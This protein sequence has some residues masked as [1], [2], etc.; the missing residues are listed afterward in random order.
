MFPDAGSSHRTLAFQALNVLQNVYNNT[1][2]CSDISRLIAVLLFVSQAVDE[3]EEN[4]S[5]VSLTTEEVNAIQELWQRV[6]MLTSAFDDV[7]GRLI[8]LRLDMPDVPQEE[9][10]D[11]SDL[12]TA[13]IDTGHCANVATACERLITLVRARNVELNFKRQMES[14]TTASGMAAVKQSTKAAFVARRNEALPDLQVL[15][16][17]HD[18][19]NVV[20]FVLSDVAER[21]SISLLS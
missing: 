2:L 3:S 5:S 21:A 11:T 12:A 4:N 10:Y 20:A 13:F 16:N 19:V 9:E 14:V 8:N 1:T 18:L 15:Q 6:R 17:E 7:K